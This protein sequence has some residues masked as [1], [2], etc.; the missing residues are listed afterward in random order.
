M[1]SLSDSVYN[2]LK[3]LVELYNKEGAP[4]K[5]KDIAN[6]LKIHEGYVRNM[7][8]I[9]KSMGLVISKAG[10][11]GGYIP[12]SKATDILSRQTFS[13][14]IVSMGNVVG[15]AL[16]ITLIGL[17][18]ERPYAS[19]RVVGDLSNYVEKEVRVGPLPSGVVLI[20]KIIKADVE[21]LIEVSSIVS[22]PRT[23]VKNIMTPNPIV[24][25]ADDPLEAYIK[26]FV[27]K[28]FRGIPVVDDDK[29]PI[30]LL[31]ASRVMDALANCNLKTKVGNLMLRNPPVINEDEDIHEAIR[32]M[33]SSGIGRLLVVNSED[34]LVGIITRTDILTRIATLEQLV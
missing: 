8:S 28:R 18:S 14:P 26:Y 16:D 13:V 6:V 24:A 21:A 4:V 10:P 19:M 1:S 29:R 25:R 3:A 12:T 27:E 31:M 34:K 7:L 23:S 5:S 11:H 20:G 17:L 9:L 32:L 2:V 30:G 15:Y 22:I 33:V